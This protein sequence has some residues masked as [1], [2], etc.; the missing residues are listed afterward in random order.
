MADILSPEQSMLKYVRY[1]PVMLAIFVPICLAVSVA[2]IIAGT[3]KISGIMDL[4]VSW[5]ALP[6]GLFLLCFVF[7]PSLSYRKMINFLRNNG[8]YYEAVA[9]FPL[10]QSFLDDSIRLGSKYIFCKR[11]CVILRYCDIFRVYQEADYDG[12]IER[13]R[14]FH[15]VDTSGEVWY[16]CALKHNTDIQPGL[17]DVIDFMLSKN[18]GIKVDDRT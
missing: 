9:D 12:R 8:I 7:I 10:A 5:L 17:D 1:S 11:H 14:E 15:A 18:P 4:P 3:L 13:S 6:V 16:L 2:L